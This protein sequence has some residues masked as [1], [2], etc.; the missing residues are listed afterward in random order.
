MSDKTPD[1]TACLADLG[2]A[3]QL[4]SAQ[5]TTDFRIGT[6]GYIAPEILMSKSYGTSVDI[7]SLGCVL[8]F[9]LTGRQPHWDDDSSL[10]NHKVCHEE[11]DLETDT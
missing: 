4:D 5:D 11:L 8:Y 1:A 2:S 6:P 7:W 9:L 3:I 10:R